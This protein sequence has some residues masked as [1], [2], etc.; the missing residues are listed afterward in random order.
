MARVVDITATFPT[1]SDLREV[2]S[3]GSAL[4][5]AGGEDLGDL[6]AILAN[7]QPDGRD[8]GRPWLLAPVDLQAV[9]AAGVTFAMSMLERVSEERAS[10]DLAAAAQNADAVRN[11]QRFS[12]LVADEDDGI[13]GG[14]EFTQ[15]L[16]QFARLGRRQNGCRLVKDKDACLSGK[17]TQ[18]L[19][20]LLFA[21]RK[22]ADAGAWK[23]L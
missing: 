10:G 20:A 18:D 12:R 17:Y 4:R 5:E 11:L 14:H 9:K 16:E 23:S 1:V 3:P 19:D 7:T 22:I 6:D 21:G 15:R 8:A 2:A 13:A